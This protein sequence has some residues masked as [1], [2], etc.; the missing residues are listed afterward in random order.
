LNLTAVQH[1]VVQLMAAASRK[2]HGSGGPFD[3]N[4]PLS[5]TRGV[6]C[7]GTG[8]DYQ[9]VFTFNSNVV[10]GNASVPPSEGSVSEITFSGNTMIVNL[11]GVT[12]A[13]YVTVNLSNVSDSTGNVLATA[14]VTMGVLLGDVNGDGQVDSSDLLKVKQQ[15]LQPVTTFNFQEDVNTDGNIDSSDLI[16]VKGQTLTGLP[17]PP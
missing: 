13:Q 15:T 4:L 1:P 16:T 6:E 7:R 9:L 12:N 5:G 14:S 2:L 3:L 11:T 10:S 8:G 17:S